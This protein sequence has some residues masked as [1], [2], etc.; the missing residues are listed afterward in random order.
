MIPHTPAYQAPEV[1]TDLSSKNDV[2]SFGIML[3]ERL[4]GKSS[5]QICID[6]KIRTPER[7]IL[8]MLKPGG[9]LQVYGPFVNANASLIIGTE[10]GL[11]RDIFDQIR[12]LAEQCTSL[13]PRDRPTARELVRAL[14]AISRSYQRF[15]SIPSSISNPNINQPE[16]S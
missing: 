12:Y 10:P 6:S 3:Y 4:S 13:D 8:K 9:V 5:S 1:E 7:V 11:T 15:P 16:R 14:D 2:W